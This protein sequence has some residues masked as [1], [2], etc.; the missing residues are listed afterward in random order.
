MLC[1][2]LP[3]TT[4]NG[5]ICRMPF[6]MGATQRTDCVVPSTTAGGESPPPTTPGGSPGEGGDSSATGTPGGGSSGGGGGG[7]GSG[8]RRGGGALHEVCALD[9]GSLDTC[10]PTYVPP[11]TLQPR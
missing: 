6:R 10:L 11:P 2:P 7:G 1:P 8:R 4:L 3:R 5:Q 9:D